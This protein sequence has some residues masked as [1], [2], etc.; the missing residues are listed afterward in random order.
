MLFQSQGFILIFLPIA[1]ASYYLAAGSE[2]V[3]HAVLIAA[4][5]VFYGWWDARFVVL[6]VAQ[7][8]ATWLFAYWHKRS[9]RAA[10]LYLGIALNL[11]SLAT[12]KYLNFLIAS[13]ESLVGF[14]LPRADLLLPIGISFFSFQL[15][16]YLV[17]RLRGDAPVY[18]F[19]PFALFVLLFPHLI[20]G[21]IVRHN[22]LVPQLA[23]DPR[24]D[25]LW[26][27]VTAGLVLFTIGFAKKV[28]VAD[29]LARD[30]V[31][32]LFLDAVHRS[33]TFAQAWN[34]IVA[35]T[36]QIFLD[37][38]AYTE[39]AIGIALL[40][41]LL[42]PDNFRRPYLATDLREFWRR[43][44]ITLSNFIRDYLYIP[45]GG[46]RHGNVRYVAATLGSMAI[47]GLWHGAGWTF[48]AWGVWHGIGLVVCRF[49]QLLKRPLPALVGWLVTMQFVIVGWVLFRAAN[50]ATALDILRSLLGLN[51]F[52]GRFEQAPTIM[53]GILVSVLVPSAH[54]M[55]DR[56]VRPMRTAAV[57]LGLLAVWC[58]LKVGK[59][60][61]VN[62]IYFQF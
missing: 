21:P 50:F 15:I 51:G 16:S 60:A 28:L 52:G 53:A 4:S 32:P 33:L 7:I 20:A 2:R 3:R 17:D 41:G 46:S 18:P 19:R 40:F 39:M 49:W 9:G 62:F 45:L 42:L 23:L 30:C 13:A 61:P 36:L 47:C 59:G 48:V 8:G 11:A 1:V 25:G 14:A 58:I 44:H 57:G 35:F 5:L 54:E 24:R 34:A 10:A 12:F 22:E 31:N 27:R 55:K 29:V 56:W 43:W 26:F 6:P 38:S 37:F